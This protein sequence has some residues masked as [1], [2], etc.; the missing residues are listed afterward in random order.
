MRS[1][2]RTFLVIRLHVLFCDVLPSTR[3][4]A[5]AEGESAVAESKGPLDL[6]AAI[7]AITTAGKVY[8]ESKL[9]PRL[10]IAYKRWKPTRAPDAPH[11]PDA[12]F[13]M[14]LVK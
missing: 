12:Y 6:T 10:P 3:V 4:A 14:L 9:P 8:S 5:P 11:E 2:L 13:P 7:A 1:P